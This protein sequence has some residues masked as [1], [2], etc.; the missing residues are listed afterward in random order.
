M[1]AQAAVRKPAPMLA[2]RGSVATQCLGATAFGN[3]LGEGLVDAASGTGYSAQE[4]F[5]RDEIAQFNADA[6][7]EQWIAQSDA[8]QQ[9]RMDEAAAPYREQQWIAQ[10]DAIMARRADEALLGR[11]GMDVQSD[12]WVASNGQGMVGRKT[13]LTPVRADS[14][15]SAKQRELNRFAAM[16]EASGAE[17]PWSFRDASMVQRKLDDARELQAIQSRL[18]NGPSMSAWDGRSGVPSATASHPFYNSFQYQA[19]MSVQDAVGVVALPEIAAAKTASIVGGLMLRGERLL[20]GAGA[21][22]GL[23]TSAVISTENA[24]QVLMSNGLSAEKAQSYAASFDGPI[25]ARIVRPGE[26]FLRYTDSPT[27][28]GSFL[29]QTQFANPAAAVDGLYLGPFGNGATYVQTVTA[30]EKTLV[31]EGAIANGGNGVG[32]VVVNPKAFQFGTG[33]RY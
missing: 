18:A 21:S 6:L 7:D 8:T 10:S 15:A 14:A 4:A 23:R 2:L 26:T 16:S 22:E 3:A 32:Q 28:G 13:M 1:L 11:N 20:G 33:V 12:E 19:A 17:A 29:T 27:S 25:K 30:T 24:Q 9:R 31:L 5:R